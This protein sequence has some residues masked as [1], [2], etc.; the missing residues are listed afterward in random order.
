ML[1][2]PAPHR[3]FGAVRLS[4][5]VLLAVHVFI[6]A[7]LVATVEGTYTE[8]KP[9]PAAVHSLVAI[10][11]DQTMID[12]EIKNA[13]PLFFYTLTR[14]AD[15]SVPADNNGTDASSDDASSDAR[16][17]ETNDASQTDRAWLHIGRQSVNVALVLMVLG[18]ALMLTS[19]R[20]RHHLRSLGFFAAVAA[21][22][23][24]FPACYMLEL[25]GGT[26][27]DEDRT[28]SNTPG[29]NLETVTFVHTNASSDASLT[30][31][32]FQLEADFSGYDLGLVV[33]ENRTT[34][35]EAV[36]EPGS[37]DAGSFIAFE[38]S[39]NVQLGKNLDSLLVLPFMWYLMPAMKRPDGHSPPDGENISPNVADNQPFEGGENA[40]N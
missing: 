20:W 29:A 15:A 13:T 32:G 28:A 27:E 14:D 26:D 5:T 24:V 6:S 37:K 40:G 21:F 36:P 10:D 1:P 9:A 17:D 2:R 4:I 18:E 7:W 8:G 35:A 30:W 19:L 11:K 33:P 16:E 12:V 3:A 34:V 23:I 25:T 38:S 39:F 22:A 31:L